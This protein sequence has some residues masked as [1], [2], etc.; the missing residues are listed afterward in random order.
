MTSR[1]IERV[2]FPNVSGGKYCLELFLRSNYRVKGRSYYICS[3]DNLGDGQ[4]VE[5]FKTET[6][7]K[8]SKNM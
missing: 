4:R 5:L 2:L 3:G 1:C 8:K 6:K 7:S